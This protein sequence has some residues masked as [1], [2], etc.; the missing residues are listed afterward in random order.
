[1]ESGRSEFRP[2]PGS[3]R[4]AQGGQ[5]W[6]AVWAAAMAGLGS[7]W[8][9]AYGGSAWSV[10]LTI[11]VAAVG[12]GLVS[13][14]LWRRHRLG[15]VL[16]DGHGLTVHA[17][18]LVLPGEPPLDWSHVTAVVAH[19]LDWAG[20][21]IIRHDGRRSR[22][23]AQHFGTTVDELAASVGRYVPVGDPDAAYRR[24]GEH[25]HGG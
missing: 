17:E 3:I 10:A 8:G 18:G 16:R 22:V 12:I 13:V 21:E 25:W 4:R 20:L 23:L 2:D 7:T 6:W 19:R 9:V 24:W 14:A 15:R 11:V 5:V 1:M